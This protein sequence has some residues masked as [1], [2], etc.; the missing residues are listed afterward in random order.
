[1]SDLAHS[2]RQKGIIPTQTISM[3]LYAYLRSLASR[4]LIDG[5]FRV[6]M[7]E[8]TPVLQLRWQGD[9]GEPTTY[10]SVAGDTV[11]STTEPTEGVWSA[12]FNAPD[13]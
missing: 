12:P 10:W 11:T 3:T 5:A 4:D 8:G 2:V 7:V 1:M 13:A 6:V 9:A